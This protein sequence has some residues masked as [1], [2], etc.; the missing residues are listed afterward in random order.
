MKTILL[1]YTIAFMRYNKVKMTTSIRYTD[2][3]EIF[4]DNP[5]NL[6]AAQNR[7]KEIQQKTAVYLRRDI[8]TW[9]ICT[10]IKTSEHYEPKEI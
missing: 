2:H 10:V 1:A 8:Y 6:L 3:F 4:A 5:D 9:N 7:L